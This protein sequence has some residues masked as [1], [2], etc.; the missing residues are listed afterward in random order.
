MEDPQ[1]GSAEQTISGIQSELY[2]EMNKNHVFSEQDID[3]KS[4][5]N[6]HMNN[7]NK[8]EI[9]V[10][11]IPL[12]AATVTA[13]SK[14]QVTQDQTVSFEDR[15]DKSAV[16][17]KLFEKFRHLKEHKSIHDVNIKSEYDV[18]TTLT[19]IYSTQDISIKSDS[20][21]DST[22]DGAVQ[23]TSGILKL[24][25]YDEMDI[26]HVFSE[27]DP[28]MK[29][30]SDNHLNINQEEIT[31]PSI[32]VTALSKS[33]VIQEQTA[34]FE[35]M[36]YKCAV[37]GKQFQ[38]FGYLKEHKR[39]HSGKK[40]CRWARCDICS[41]LFRQSQTVKEHKRIHSGERSNKCSICRKQFQQSRSPNIQDKPSSIN[42]YQHKPTS[43]NNYQDKSTRI[44][45]SCSLKA[46]KSIHSREKPYIC[47]MCSKQY[48]RLN[49]LKHHM[50]SHSIDQLYQCNVCGK[51]FKSNASIKMHSHTHITPPKI[52]TCAL[53]GKRFIDTHSFI[54]HMITH[55]VTMTNS[56][57]QYCGKS[58][59]ESP[60]FMEHSLG[61]VRRVHRCKVCGRIYED[62]YSVIKHVKEHGTPIKCDDSDMWLRIP[63]KFLTEEDSKAKGT[64]QSDI[65]FESDDHMNTNQEEI[66]IPVIPKSAA[67]VLSKS[68]AIQDETASFE[69][70]SDSNENSKIQD[71]SIKS[72]LLEVLITDYVVKATSGI[73]IKSESHEETDRN[74]VF[75]KQ[76][77][78]IKSESDDHMNINQE[79]ITV[80]VIPNSAATVTILSKSPAIQDQTASF[81]DR[82]YKCDVCEKVFDHCCKL[83][84]HKR[85]H[86]EKTTY[87]CG[88]CGKQFRL[89]CTLKQHKCIDKVEKPFKCDVC[90]KQFQ[91]SCT[92]KHHKRIHIGERKFT[93]DLCG[94]QFRLAIHL[95][96]H[97]TIHSTERPYKCDVC[98]IGFRTPAFMRYHR[99]VHTKPLYQNSNCDIIYRNHVFHEKDTKNKSQ[100]DDHM[101]R[102]QEE[103]SVPV[104]PNSAATVSY[105]RSNC[106]L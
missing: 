15:S 64:G 58:Y 29:S 84:E 56:I 3:I 86:F 6:E 45:K 40:A 67:T 98:G 96:E 77:T 41:K 27:Q 37:C 16:C 24:E 100:P 13:L 81:E 18:D 101:N 60:C 78:D 87:Q 39:I 47:G 66:V 4:K 102:N 59:T 19:T 94:K 79:E 106:P 11:G 95:K 31:V 97:V 49:F 71:I 62:Y 12:S 20:L 32:P 65:K 74:H 52:L 82:S 34:N 93:C 9:A 70:R 38:T 25:S 22:T 103:I 50:I 30:E 17:G 92:L 55:D 68:P 42:D 1:T 51:C 85:V 88:V 48:R 54:N 8:E 10:P 7:I 35:D 61:G 89:I 76:E 91:Q 53:C 33:P 21:E 73:I 99:K 44:N 104:I 105:T 14:S 69:D 26:D 57:C 28:H 2:D 23:A 43:I 46:H 75:N 36:S 63:Y 5:S 83:Q 80:P 72:E 90:G